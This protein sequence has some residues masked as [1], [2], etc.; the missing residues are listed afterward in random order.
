MGEGRVYGGLCDDGAHGEYKIR[1]AARI[2]KL[3]SSPPFGPVRRAGKTEEQ[4]EGGALTGDLFLPRGIS[5]I[6]VIS[7]AP[8]FQ[9]IDILRA[10]AQVTAWG[11]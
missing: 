3:W 9:K 11:V 1:T 7:K 6:V 10:D 2:S 8:A 5:V 4:K